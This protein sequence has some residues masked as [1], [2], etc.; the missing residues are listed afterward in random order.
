[1]ETLLQNYGLE[2]VVGMIGTVLTLLAI[3]VLRFKYFEK[4]KHHE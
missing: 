1:M 4:K 3:R 2:I